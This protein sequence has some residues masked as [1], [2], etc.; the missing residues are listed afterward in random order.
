MRKFIG[1]LSCFFFIGITALSQ[2][3]LNELTVDRPGIAES[4]FTV[5]KGSYQFEVG[6]DYFKRYNGE[7]YNL[8]IVLFRTGIT[9]KTELRISSRHLLDKTE[10]PAFNEISP[11]SVGVKV[12]LIEQHHGFP[13]I[14]VLANVVFPIGDSAPTENIGPEIL[15]LFQNDFYPNTAINY[16]IGYLWDFVRQRNTFTASMCFNYLPTEKLGL[17]IEYY[18]FV[19]DSWPG[20]QGFDGGFTYLLGPRFQVDL[21]VGLSYMEKGNNLFVSSGFSFRIGKN[22]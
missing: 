5:P 4:P 8:P 6:F 19:P 17:F 9:D 15:L 22:E 13:E 21:S 3:K 11:L 12:H 2:T 14:D 1:L 20:E 7:I 18:G 16:N 10:T